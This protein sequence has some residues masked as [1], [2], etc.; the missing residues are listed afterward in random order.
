VIGA[1]WL[2]AELAGKASPLPVAAKAA[3][4]WV[5]TPAESAALQWGDDTAWEFAIDDVLRDG[6]RRA[7]LAPL[8]VE[9]A[10]DRFGPQA[11]RRANVA[12]TAL[13]LCGLM[14][15]HTEDEV[16]ELAKLTASQRATARALLGYPDVISGLGHGIPRD[17]ATARRWLEIDPPS[18]LELPV[19]K[20]GPPRWLHLRNM[21][22][23]A[24]QQQIL[25]AA[26]E[27]L[28]GGKRLQ[29]MQ[30]LASGAYGIKSAAELKITAQ[31][32]AGEV[33]ASKD[34]A[35]PWAK[36]A[37]A[38]A[39]P[40]IRTPEL[41]TAMATLVR[42]GEPISP[43]WDD[44]VG[45]LPPDLAREVLAAIPP[46]RRAAL[47]LRWAQTI[48]GG[49]A[50]FLKNVAPV[51]DLVGSSALA[52]LLRPWLK[53][54]TVKNTQGVVKLIEPLLGRAQSN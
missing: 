43:E 15:D 40:G 17:G 47:A 27:G 39:P 2:A 52:K 26:V 5:A 21:I 4:G 41:L 31:D 54:P 36:Q 13:R 42:A 16:A 8:L 38:D 44:L 24:K 50:T 53:L 18:P 37:L 29:V 1:Q 33:A 46:A 25:A 11:E 6:P 28:E 22:G 9:A 12:D 34:G 14:T 10:L 32:L 49:H 30:A 7:A 3:A 23:K 20:G 51:F 35:V 45:C 48:R 19:K